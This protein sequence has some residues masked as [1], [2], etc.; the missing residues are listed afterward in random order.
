MDSL[1]FHAFIYLVAAVITVPLAKRLG[2]GSVLGYL[3]A[4]VL[5]GPHVFNLVGEAGGD[6]MHIAEFG[7]VM[8][9][10]LVGL[11]LQPALLWKLR[12]QLL[13]LG[14]LQVFGTAALIAVI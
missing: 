1:L 8:M 5:I 9:L 2:L 3:L 12:L 13:G 10:F 7:V 6:V 11:E 4:G 14:G